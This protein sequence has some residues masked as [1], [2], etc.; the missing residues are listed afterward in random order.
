MVALVSGIGF[1][2]YS[3]VVHA[4]DDI[5][6]LKQSSARVSFVPPNDR[7]SPRSTQ[8]GASRIELP[9]ACDGLPLLPRNGLGLTTQNSP[10]I[11]VYFSQGTTV[12]QAKLTLKSLDEAESEY[13]D[14]VVTLPQDALA[15]NGGVVSFE[16]PEVESEL[17]LNKEYA[18]SLILMCEGQLRP[19]SPSLSG[20]LKRV[21]RG[22]LTAEKLD[23]SLIEQAIA[24]GEAGIWYD[25]LAVLAEIRAEDE[26][27]AVSDADWKGVMSTVG[28]D[29]IA[30]EPVLLD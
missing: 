6:Q 28:L 27:N 21:E 10:S 24:Y 25:L 30:T 3:T 22:G 26:S 16:I 11:F 12:A 14:T 17:A 8:S 13:Y 15:E 18:W 1:L 7:P 23:S 20:T 19:D 29:A 9:A 5:D 2:R 4:I